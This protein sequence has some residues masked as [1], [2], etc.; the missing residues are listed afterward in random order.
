MTFGGLVCMLIPTMILLSYCSDLQSTAP[1]WVYVLNAVGTFIY[2]VQY[3]QY[4]TI[5]LY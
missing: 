2:Q 4:N 1:A 5:V 3:M